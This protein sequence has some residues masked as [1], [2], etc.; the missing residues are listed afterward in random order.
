MLQV[1]KKS[2][3]PAFRRNLVDALSQG[4]TETHVRTLT[5]P[6]GP[7][8]DAELTW[9]PTIGLWSYLSPE[10][11]EGRRWL[12]WYGIDIGQPN[13]PLQPAVEI[14]LST[15]PTDKQPNGRA[16][17]DLGTGEHFLGHKGSLGG[18]RGGQLTLDEF[19]RHIRG[20]GKDIIQL[21]AKREES[22][23]VIGGLKDSRFL[24]HVRDYV[25]ECA[26]LRAEAKSGRLSSCGSAPDKSGGFRPECDQDGFMTRPAA[27]VRRIRRVHGRVVNALKDRL[28]PSARNSAHFSM[29]P[30]LYLPG[31]AGR[32]ATLFEVKATSDTQSWFTAIGQLIVYAADQNPA[33]RRVLVCPGKLEHSSFKQALK[34]FKISVVTFEETKGRG[35]EF[36][37]LDELGF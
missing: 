35:V 32:M 7:I 17:V 24:T 10:S 5:T 11:Y 22:V 15:S 23:F 31:K 34:A 28:G 37:G 20:F 12:C 18:G 25:A 36:K 27:E 6:G 33:P 26:R 30:D 4:F 1:I 8:P 29:R 16:L 13:R 2:D 21:D 14:N 3:L 9:H 19:Q